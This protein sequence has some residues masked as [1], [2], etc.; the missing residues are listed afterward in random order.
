MWTTLVE[1]QAVA[2]LPIVQPYAN[3]GAVHSSERSTG[4]HGSDHPSASMGSRQ[5]SEPS[6]SPAGRATCPGAANSRLL[7][8]AAAA[9]QGAR[10]SALSS[11]YRHRQTTLQS[12]W[13]S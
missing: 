3:G 10:S 4:S 2:N 7:N 12:C 9:E 11:I 6:G 13:S 1:A 8:L 5:S